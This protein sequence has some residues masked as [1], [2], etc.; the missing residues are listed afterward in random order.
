MST[1]PR[2]VVT[3]TDPINAE[4]LSAARHVAP[5]I[6]MKYGLEWDELT[7]G[8]RAE[9]LAEALAEITEVPW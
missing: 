6:A 8:E 7:Q 2:H 3:D 1:E 4:Q 5:R 9:C